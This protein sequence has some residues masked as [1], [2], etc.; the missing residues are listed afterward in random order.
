MD[1]YFD[2]HGLDEKQPSSFS[3]G[4]LIVRDFI[5]R[6]ISLFTMTEQDLSRAGIYHR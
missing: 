6:L 3:A 4:L 2:K 5:R 1:N